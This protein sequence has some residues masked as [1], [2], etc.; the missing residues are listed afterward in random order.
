[1]QRQPNNPDLIVNNLKC[2]LKQLSSAVEASQWH[3]VRAEDQRITELLSTARSMGMTNDLS[4]I[5]AQ[6]RKHYAD[7]LVQLKQMQQDTEARLQG[8]SQSREGI[9]AY[10]ASQVEQRQ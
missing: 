3:R 8:I 1:M 6:L 7:I 4:P 5:L 10:A 2:R 9:L